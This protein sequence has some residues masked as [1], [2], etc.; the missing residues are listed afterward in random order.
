M[1]VLVMKD[2]GLAGKSGHAS[3]FE[4]ARAVKAAGADII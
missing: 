3:T 4:A 2:P 1:D